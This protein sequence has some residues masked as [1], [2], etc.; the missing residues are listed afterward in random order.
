MLHATGWMEG[1]LVA[2]FEKMVLDAELLQIRRS[3]AEK[4]PAD[5]WQ[6]GGRCDSSS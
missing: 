3:N 2:S 4:K 1:G 5:R 6:T